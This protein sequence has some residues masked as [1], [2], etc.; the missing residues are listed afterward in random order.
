MFLFRFRRY[1]FKHFYIYIFSFSICRASVLCFFAATRSP[2][3]V[4]F[5][6]LS[7]SLACSLS[8]PIYSASFFYYMNVVCCHFSNFQDSDDVF[9]L[10]DFLFGIVVAHL[11]MDFGFVC[12]IIFADLLISALNSVS[13]V[14]LVFGRCL[15]SCKCWLFV[16]CRFLFLFI[17][18]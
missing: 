18:I 15:I 7:F 11:P 12:L 16:S 9:R 8:A 17:S 4:F 6:L 10:D 5:S 1:D 2:I 14:S 13:V 3:M